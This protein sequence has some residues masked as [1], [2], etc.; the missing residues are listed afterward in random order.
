[1]RGSQ[2]HLAIVLGIA[3]APLGSP[4]LAAAGEFSINACQS[5]RLGFS[6]QAFDTFAIRAWSARKAAW[7]RRPVR[8]S[9]ET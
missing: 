9:W 2:A 5:D 1:M 7:A 4:A 8:S 6:S 3:I